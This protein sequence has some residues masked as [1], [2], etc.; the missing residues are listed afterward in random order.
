MHT[1][2]DIILELFAAFPL[3]YIWSNAKEAKQKEA[4]EI[5]RH[6]FY[7]DFNVSHITIYSRYCSRKSVLSVFEA[8]QKGGVGED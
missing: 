8:S 3:T 2:F 7:F 1:M 6:S 4:S 5:F